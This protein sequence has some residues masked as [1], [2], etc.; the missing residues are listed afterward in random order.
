M[1]GVGKGVKWS[2]C[3]SEDRGVELEVGFGDEHEAL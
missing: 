2:L 3:V 1:I